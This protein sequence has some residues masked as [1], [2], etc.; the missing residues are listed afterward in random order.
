MLISLA[1]PVTAYADHS[2]N[3]YH[4]ARTKNPVALQIVN[5][6]TSDW[7]GQL[8]DAMSQWSHSNIIDLEITLSDIA[9]NVR[10]RCPMVDGKL[11]ICNAKYGK[12]G[13]LGQTIIGFD[14]NGHIDKARAKLNDSYFK[15]W[16]LER[17]NHVM[18][19]EIGHVFGL[20]HT[21]QDGSS[22]QSCMDLSKDPLSQ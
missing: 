7:E 2:W 6:V 17:K 13:W 1:I 9:A 15:L 14:V 11:H 5:S 19:H 22:Q 3:D 8:V 4:W 21:S 12:N 10:N 20:W 18:C 16:T